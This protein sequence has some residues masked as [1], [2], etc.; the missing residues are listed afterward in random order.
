MRINDVF[1]ATSASQMFAYP[2]VFGLEETTFTETAL[3]GDTLVGYIPYILPPRTRVSQVVVGRVGGGNTLPTSAT[4]GSIRFQFYNGDETQYTPTTRIGGEV[5]AILAGA[6]AIS[7]NTA[8][9]R[10]GFSVGTSWWAFCPISE[11]VANFSYRNPRLVYMGVQ[12]QGGGAFTAITMT[13]MHRAVWAPALVR[14]SATV[15]WGTPFA[16]N[17]AIVGMAGGDTT[18]RP[19]S[20][21]RLTAI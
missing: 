6:G 21:L 1:P 20:V 4:T 16:D 15:A 2:T 19:T 9:P 11:T 8:P 13:A 12:V 5:Q 17:P 7:S 3:S 14:S 10:W 18:A